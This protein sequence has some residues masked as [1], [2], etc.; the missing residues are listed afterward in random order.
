MLKAIALGVAAGILLAGSAMA[1]PFPPPAVDRAP[2]VLLV[3]NDK[4]KHKNNPGKK[5]GHYKHQHDDDRRS[6]SRR[7]TFDRD[8]RSSSRP[9]TY[10]RDRRYGAQRFDGAPGYGSTRPPAYFSPPSYY[11]F[12]Y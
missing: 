2:E 1:H 7:G 4:H 3:K 11:G 8:W 9:G 12:P 6:S 10:D 5:L